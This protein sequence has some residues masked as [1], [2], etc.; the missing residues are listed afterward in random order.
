MP[1]EFFATG[2]GAILMVRSFCDSSKRYEFGS[3]GK[4]EG[5]K[6]GLRE[7]GWEEVIQVYP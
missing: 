7:W 4:N 2:C 1:S 6:R 3:D 5:W